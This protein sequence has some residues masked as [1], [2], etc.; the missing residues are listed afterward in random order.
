MYYYRFEDSLSSQSRCEDF[1][2]LCVK[3]FIIHVLLCRHIIEFWAFEV[4]YLYFQL[5]FVLAHVYYNQG[6]G[7]LIKYFK[8]LIQEIIYRYW[9]NLPHAFW[10]GLVP[11]IITTC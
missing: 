3:G 8:P 10:Y 11:H 6:S 1:H 4:T 9:I 7:C 5:L 2:R